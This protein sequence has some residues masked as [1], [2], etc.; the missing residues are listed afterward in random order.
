MTLAAQMV[1]KKVK[2]SAAADGQII[3][4]IEITSA[5]NTSMALSSFEKQIKNSRSDMLVIAVKV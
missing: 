3:A 4:A 2:N 1:G 5:T